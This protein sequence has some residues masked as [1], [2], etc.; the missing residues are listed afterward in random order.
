MRQLGCQ[1]S[2]YVCEL[3]RAIA[4]WAVPKLSR[5]E[6]CCCFLKQVFTFGGFI[7]LLHFYI[8]THSIN[9][10]PLVLRDP[11]AKLVQEELKTLRFTTATTKN[12]PEAI[13][14]PGFAEKVVQQHDGT[15]SKEVKQEDQ[16]DQNDLVVRPCSFDLL[17]KAVL[18]EVGADSAV[19]AWFTQCAEM[20]LSDPEELRS[21]IMSLDEDKESA[22]FHFGM[23]RDHALRPACVQHVE[24]MGDDWAKEPLSVVEVF[25]G[26]VL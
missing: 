9:Q 17:W 4:V 11:I 1:I 22:S 3:S 6:A 13:A 18:Q 2:F 26:S 25:S 7:V 21:H 20:A 16:N 15:L 8:F 10:I 12:A 23:V 24:E 19:D 14:L 5:W